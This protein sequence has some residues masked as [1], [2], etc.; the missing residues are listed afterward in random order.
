[1]AL[2]QPFTVLP[3]AAGVGTAGGRVAR[4]AVVHDGNGAVGRGAGARQERIHQQT[5]LG[6]GQAGVL[7][8]SRSVSRT[9]KKWASMTSVAWRCQPCQLRPS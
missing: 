3:A 9:T 6:H 1:M 8:L 5:G 7:F 4:P 2:K